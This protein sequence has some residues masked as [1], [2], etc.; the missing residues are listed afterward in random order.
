MQRSNIV[1]QH[2]FLGSVLVAGLALASSLLVLGCAADADSDDGKL[3]ENAPAVVDQG[4]SVKLPFPVPAGPS[5]VVS[6]Q[7]DPFP[8]PPAKVVTPESTPLPFPV[9]AAQSMTPQNAA[10]GDTSN[11]TAFPVPAFTKP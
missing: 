3:E 4:S 9:P 2:S 6:A 7:G 8:I 11:G 10:S 1:N 5:K